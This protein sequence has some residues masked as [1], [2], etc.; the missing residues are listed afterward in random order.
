MGVTKVS[1]CQMVVLGLGRGEGGTLGERSDL[2]H[3]WIRFGKLSSKPTFVPL[4]F[5]F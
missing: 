1:T 5:L 3:H 2:G 4:G